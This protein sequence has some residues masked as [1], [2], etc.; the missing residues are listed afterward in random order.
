MNPL[1]TSFFI[2]TACH[3]Y[4]RYAPHAARLIDNYKCHIQNDI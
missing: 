3:S 1:T 4:C 2:G